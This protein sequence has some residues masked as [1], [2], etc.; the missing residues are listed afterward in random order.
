MYIERD[1]DERSN[2]SAPHYY[3]FSQLIPV[4]DDVTVILLLGVSFMLSTNPT[5][6]F[7]V[8]LPSSSILGYSFD[9][10]LVSIDV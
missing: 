2:S 5:F 9:Y 1:E 3:P 6:V 10:L 4:K 8:L 7:L